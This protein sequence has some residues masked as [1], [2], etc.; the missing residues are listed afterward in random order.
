MGSRENQMKKRLDIKSN[1]PDNWG[2]MD[3][4]GHFVIL[5]E[6]LVKKSNAKNQE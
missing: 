1:P 5:V 4:Y 2:L 6:T 3:L